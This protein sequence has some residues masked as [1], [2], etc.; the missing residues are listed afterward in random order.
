M[1]PTRIRFGRTHHRQ[2]NGRK[3]TTDFAQR[4]CCAVATRGKWIACLLSASLLSGII[5]GTVIAQDLQ[6][7]VT[8]YL[9]DCD[10]RNNAVATGVQVKFD[11]TPFPMGGN[12][13]GYARM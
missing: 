7:F 10:F 2:R 11:N 8:T 4:L 9:A 13:Q 12:G 3:M 6:V 1:S 5:S